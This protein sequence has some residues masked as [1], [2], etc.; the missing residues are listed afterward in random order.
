MKQRGPHQ[1]GGLPVRA[2]V[3]PPTAPAASAWLGACICHPQGPV[4][5]PGSL[6]QV[7]PTVATPLG[8]SVSLSAKWMG[9]LRHPYPGLEVL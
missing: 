3:P 2:N 5:G 9:W 7:Q 1:A 6:S 4:R 8:V